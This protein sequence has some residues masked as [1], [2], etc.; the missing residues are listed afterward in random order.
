MITKTNYRQ[1]NA[2]SFIKLEIM[3]KVLFVDYKGIKINKTGIVTLIKRYWSFSRSP[4]ISIRKLLLQFIP[5]MLSIR[6]F[7]NYDVSEYYFTKLDKIIQ[8]H[9]DEL[10]NISKVIDFLYSEMYDLS[11]ILDIRKPYDTIIEIPA[12]S[13]L[14]TSREVIPLYTNSTFIKEVIE[15]NP[16]IK[17]AVAYFLDWARSCTRPR[18]LQ[19][20][21]VA[22]FLSL[23]VITYAEPISSLLQTMYKNYGYYFNT[24]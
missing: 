7:G 1:L 20:A 2:F 4:Q 23:N 17:G 9:T 14:E 15:E 12:P 13:T 21:T 24:T 16:D 6:R 8:N 10:G 5:D 19:V 3:C 11:Q 22:L 18:K